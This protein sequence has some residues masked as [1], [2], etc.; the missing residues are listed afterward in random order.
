MI[1]VDTSVWVDHLR[2]ENDDLRRILADRYVLTHPLVIGELACGNLTNRDELLL[3]LNSLPSAPFAEHGEVLLLASE[4][5]LFGKG[6]GWI[7]MHLIASA[8]IADCI[9]WTFDKALYRAAIKV[10]VAF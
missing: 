7:D 1:L 2:K 3:L 8:L 4:R 6:L 9:L 10:R 5:R